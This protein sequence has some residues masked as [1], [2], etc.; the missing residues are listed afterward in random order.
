MAA[1]ERNAHVHSSGCGVSG[2]LIFSKACN[3]F[4]HPVRFGSVHGADHANRS[5]SSW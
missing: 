2:R 3:I 4:R 1:G 5:W